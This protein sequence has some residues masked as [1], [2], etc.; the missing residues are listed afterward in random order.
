MFCL[1]N[2]V[3]SSPVVST[4]ELLFCIYY[5]LYYIPAAVVCVFPLEFNITHIS[6]NAGTINLLLQI[7]KH[8]LTVVNKWVLVISV[9]FTQDQK[10]EIEKFLK[11]GHYI[12]VMQQDTKKYMQHYSHFLPPTPRNPTIT[13]YEIEV[14]NLLITTIVVI[15]RSPSVWY[16][17]HLYN[18]RSH[19]SLTCVSKIIC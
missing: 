10:R 6:G 19:I 18:H 8:T 15:A 12:V 14:T 7:D 17:I 4:G 1:S 9:F 3:S 2:Q 11:L 16:V 5:I 13:Q